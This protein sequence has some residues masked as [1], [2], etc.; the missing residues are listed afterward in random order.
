M[1]INILKPIVKVLRMVN[2]EK[3]YM[4]GFLYEAIQLMKKA[5]KVAAPYFSFGYLKMVNEIWSNM[6][7]NLLREA[8]KVMMRTI[9]Q[10]LCMYLHIRELDLSVHVM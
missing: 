6:L 9:N 7:L 5:I 2:R 8:D 10:N 1:V 4:M 3:K